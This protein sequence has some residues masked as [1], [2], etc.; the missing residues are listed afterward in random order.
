V[1]APGE[2]VP[3]APPAPG[4]HPTR[5]AWLVVPS[6]GAVLGS[7]GEV[8]PNVAAGFGSG[9]PGRIG[10]L[11]LDLGLLLDAASAPRI[12][13]DARPVSR[14]PSADVDLALV[15]DDTVPA[16]RVAAALAEA[17][18]ELLE[19]VRLF[20]VFRGPSIGPARR[21][22]AY[23]LRFEALDRTL[24]DAELGELRTRAINAAEA[25]VGATLR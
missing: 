9:Q 11:E 25:G 14:F 2:P 4:L 8:D 5:S 21:S 10:W 1:L 18:G 23:R 22:L 20:D 3:E 13:E 24:T 16:D 19:S 7:V 6:T 15:V 12:S 17:G